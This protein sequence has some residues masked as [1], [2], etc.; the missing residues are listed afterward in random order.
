MSLAPACITVSCVNLYGLS[1]LV[2]QKGVLFMSVVM[3]DASA[4]RS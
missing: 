2:L 4:N 1:G 3:G